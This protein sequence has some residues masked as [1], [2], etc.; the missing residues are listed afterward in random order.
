MTESFLPTLTVAGILGFLAPLITTAL[1]RFNAK[2]E[3]KQTVAIIVSVVMAV[4]ALV[5]TNGFAAI[6]SKDPVIFWILLTFSVIAVAQIAYRLVWRPT[7]VVEK[8]ALATAT[9]SEKREILAGEPATDPDG[10]QH[11]AED[12]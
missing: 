10:P 7:G 2:P 9:A 12:A 8:V 4:L 3:I 1:T 6:P 5:V 11:R